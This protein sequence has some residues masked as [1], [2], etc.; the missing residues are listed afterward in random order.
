MNYEEAERML[1]AIENEYKERDID[2]GAYRILR[3][4]YEKML[5]S[6]REEETEV[7]RGVQERKPS[8][9]K[10]RANRLMMNI[11]DLREEITVLRSEKDSEENLL[12][13]IRK[14]FDKGTIR[15]RKF[16]ELSEKHKSKIENLETQISE[17]Q[18]SIEQAKGK[19]S[20]IKGR[21]QEDINDYKRVYNE[22][23]KLF[24]R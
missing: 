19:L 3:K 9:I 17:N 16:R 18:E 22:I 2:E 4:R 14:K 1:K 13:D 24:N 6:F 7:S 5:K 20:D 15:E 11:D 12:E 23:N 10:D 21:I 8:N